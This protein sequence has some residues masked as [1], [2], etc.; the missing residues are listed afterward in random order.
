M[1]GLPSVPLLKTLGA[2]ASG[3]R[4]RRIEA[5]P[6]WNGSRFVNPEGARMASGV[7]AAWEWLTGGSPHRKPDAS[8]VP[9]VRRTREDFASPARGLR[10][11]WMG[12]GTTLVEI[13]G[14]R[15]L[16]DPLWSGNA[17]PGRLFGV[18]RFH[19]VPLAL[20]DL[21]PLDAV[22]ITHDH[23]DH[24][25]AETVTALAGRVPRWVCPLG[26]GA[27]LE[28]WGVPPQAVTEL[29]WWEST[30]LSATPEVSGVTVTAT[31]SRHFSGR[32]LTDR[33]STLWC[34][35]VLQAPEASGGHSV[36]I[37][38]DGGYSDGFRAVGERL[39]PFDVALMEMGAYNEAWADIHLGPEQAVQAALDAK[40]KM[41]L[42]VHWATF[43]LALH[44]WTEHAERA[45][46]A[47]REAGMPLALPRP[48]E[49]VDVTPEAA[50][51]EPTRWW[52]DLA[53]QTAEEAPV[54]SS[55]VDPARG[56]FH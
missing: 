11:T 30:V 7:S 19:A 28:G 1:S 46:V 20:E 8:G 15:L 54:V 18:K 25:D 23:Y 13:G 45:L 21:P 10:L 34:G 55:G 24:L 40:A 31:P 50:G 38:G 51:A 29:D 17:S 16:V 14:R 49:S 43:D 6:Q 12:H 27:R 52:P 56:L 36:Y 22:L 35:F 42:P 2:R 53:W 48:G 39:G 9:V 44:G 32:F 41:L 33:D 3:E 4:Q 5:S 47:A 37:G 26:V